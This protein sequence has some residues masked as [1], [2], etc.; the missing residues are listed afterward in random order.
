MAM[1]IAMDSGKKKIW[2]GVWEKNENAIA[3]YKK[4]GFVQ[5]GEHSFYMGD[6]EQIDLIMTKT[7]HD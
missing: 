2:L 6:E 1:E 7:L 3:F 5:T 4:L